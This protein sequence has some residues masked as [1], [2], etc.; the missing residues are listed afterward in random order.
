MSFLK[1]IDVKESK[2]AFVFGYFITR[3]LSLH[4]SGKN[5]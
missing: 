1:R 2:K 5:T 3:N 4:D